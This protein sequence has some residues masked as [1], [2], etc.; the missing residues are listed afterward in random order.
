M[1]SR[2]EKNSQSRLKEFPI[3]LRPKP[4]LWMRCRLRREKILDSPDPATARTSKP[5]I[6]PPRPT[7]ATKKQASPSFKMPRPAKFFVSL[8]LTFLLFVRPLY[9]DFKLIDA[10]EEFGEKRFVKTGPERLHAGPLRIHPT[11]RTK[12]AYDNNILL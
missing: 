1:R 10:I 8:F 5:M 3:R 7:P 9:A 11:L 12:A 4:R 2:P 6:L